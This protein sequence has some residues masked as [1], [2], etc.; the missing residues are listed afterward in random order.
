MD[1]LTAAAY[2]TV[3]KDADFRGLWRRIKPEEGVPFD[4]DDAM[5]N[6]SRS[7]ALPQNNGVSVG[8]GGVLIAPSVVTYH[9]VTPTMP[10]TPPVPAPKQPRKRKTSDNPDTAGAK[11]SDSTRTTTRDRDR[12]RDHDRDRDRDREKED[13]RICPPDKDMR[14]LFTECKI[15]VG[16]ARLLSEALATATPDDL[17]SPVIVVW[18]QKCMDSQDLIFTQILWASGAVERSRTLRDVEE[19]EIERERERERK[20][21]ANTMSSLEELLADLLATNEHL[22]EALGLYKD[23]QREAEDRSRREVRMDPRFMA[24]NGTLHADASGGGD[25]SSSRISV[26]DAPAVGRHGRCRCAYASAACTSG[27]AGPRAA[28]TVYDARAPAPRFPGAT[29]GIAAL[30]LSCTP[31]PSPL[32]SRLMQPSAKALE[33]RKSKTRFFTPGD[34]ELGPGLKD[35]LDYRPGAES[36]EEN[37]AEGQRHGLCTSHNAA[38][39]R[40]QQRIRE[41]H[42][43]SRSMAR[44]RVKTLAFRAT[45]ITRGNTLA[46]PHTLERWT[47]RDPVHPYCQYIFI[48]RSFLDLSVLSVPSSPTCPRAPPA[49]VLAREAPMTA[50]LRYT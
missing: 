13:P 23:L 7:A 29:A 32:P 40:T 30:G 16:N 15:G 25:G 41:G 11:M 28:A 10:D 21:S 35:N 5:F 39:V 26:P 17:H 2:A 6:R 9:D 37:T 3:Q 14:R 44:G 20:N 22:L 1:V 43:L 27:T 49:H 4:M 47:T 34:D 19:R 38:A 42:P 46:L 36:D 8:G 50:V 12:D 18:H 24:E 31:S 33:K 45:L 48:V